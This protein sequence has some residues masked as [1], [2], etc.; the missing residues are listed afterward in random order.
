[1]SEVT[2]TVR[3]YSISYSYK[4]YTGSK[5][6]YAIERFNEEKYIFALIFREE[7]Y[8]RKDKLFNLVT[9]VFNGRESSEHWLK[10]LESIQWNTATLDGT[11]DTVDP[12]TLLKIVS[13]HPYF[14]T[15]GFRYSSDIRRTAQS[16]Y[17]ARHQFYGHL[18]ELLINKSELEKLLSLI[19]KLFALTDLYLNP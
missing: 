7:L 5:T 1:M 17:R 19:D 9:K 16:I 14:V 6:N 18:P 10:Y 15:F 13:T 4:G 2:L 3:D 12:S 8:R 11:V